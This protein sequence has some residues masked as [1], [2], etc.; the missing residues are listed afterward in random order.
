MKS[1]PLDRATAE[2]DP[3]L[4]RFFQRAAPAAAD[5]LLQE[6]RLRLARARDGYD[7]SR[8][9]EPWIWRFAWI[10]LLEHRRDAK[11]AP[12]AR[13]GDQAARPDLDP[14]RREA[15][16]LVWTCVR[17]LEDGK[18][19]QRTF[20]VL[21][22]LEGVSHARLL[23]KFSVRESASKM[24]VLRGL[25]QL[26]RILTG[27]RLLWSREKSEAADDAWELVEKVEPRAQHAITLAL[28][29]RIDLALQRELDLGGAARTPPSVDEIAIQRAHAR[30]IAAGFP[31]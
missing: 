31:P 18:S 17:D 20:V 13:A 4:K 8:P 24:R 23:E 29:G 9:A 30:L 11:H 12:L 5:D 25:E 16:R 10:V 15:R 7:P 22:A 27:D 1:D 14:A 28:F 19:R 21:H 6:T 3:A 2:L 26:E